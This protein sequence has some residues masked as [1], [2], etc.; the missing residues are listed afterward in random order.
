MT[1]DSFFL[2][3]MKKDKK[4]AEFAERFRFLQSRLDKKTLLIIFHG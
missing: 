3:M 1:V 4:Q 2:C